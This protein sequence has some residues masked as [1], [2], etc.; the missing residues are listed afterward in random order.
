MDR[1]ARSPPWG[2]ECP[3]PSR[4]GQGC[5]EPPLGTGM[6][7]AAE[8]AVTA[9]MREAAWQE[10]AGK[11][12]P[13]PALSASSK[14]AQTCCDLVLHCSLVPLRSQARGV[15]GGN[16]VSAAWGN[17]PEQLCARG[18]LL[19]GQGHPNTGMS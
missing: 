19:Q 6:L 17:P 12:K 8:A 18:L 2:Q 3:Q 16:E 4:Y 13:A 15:R 14:A 11:T 9:Q 5:P 10:G 7:A 1:N